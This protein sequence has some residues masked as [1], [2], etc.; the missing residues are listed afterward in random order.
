MQLNLDTDSRDSNTSDDIVVWYTLDKLQGVNDDYYAAVEMDA[1]NNFFIYNKGNITYTGSG[2][3][4]VTSEEEKRLFLN[5]LVAAY[6]AGMHAPRVLYKENEWNTSATI[7]SKYLPYD[8]QMVRN[9]GEVDDN[10]NPV[11]GGFLEKTLPVHFY[12]TNENL[13]LTNE[14]LYAEYYIDGTKNNS[15]IYLDGKYYKKVTPAKVERLVEEGGQVTRANEDALRPANNSMHTATF[16]YASIGLGNTEN[17]KDKYSSNIYI[18]LGY[19]PLVAPKKGSKEIS[20]P[21]SESFSKLNIVCTQ[22]FEL[23]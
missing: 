17:I 11:T 1:R 20:L 13:Q 9:T 7:T 5:T 23:R 21:A 14:E 22:L 19:E 15:D 16:D 3:K 8:P 10:G 12:T 4:S 18:R 6:R 2:H